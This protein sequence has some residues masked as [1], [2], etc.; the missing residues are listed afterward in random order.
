[1]MNGV[2]SVHVDSCLRELCATLPAIVFVALYLVVLLPIR[3]PHL[4]SKRLARIRAPFQPTLTLSEVEALQCQFALQD[5][6]IPSRSPSTP[7]RPVTSVLSR[8][9]FALFA[10][11]PLVEFI[12][13]LVIGTK[14]AIQGALGAPF[15]FMCIPFLV[16]FTWGYA[17][18]RLLH[19]PPATPPF[20]LFIL[21]I[22]H[23]CGG[24]L[25]LGGQ[26]Y[27]SGTPR[28][29]G[30]ILIAEGVHLGIVIVLL[31]L[32]IRLPLNVR[33][34]QVNKKAAVSKVQRSSCR[35]I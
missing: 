3:L 28:P 22:L 27:S 1:M 4:I 12:A 30:R 35:S 6:D 14:N 32:V 8:C 29:S 24:I 33:S 5:P 34:E 17:L 26:L 16:S 15:I 31:T 13:W 20:D 7:S 2:C 10:G 18:I 19:R 25:T 11:L 9:R 23:L 21:F